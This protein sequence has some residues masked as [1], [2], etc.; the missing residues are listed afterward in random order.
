MCKRTMYKRARIP[1][2]LWE[3]R[4]CANSGAQARLGL[5]TLCY[6]FGLICFQEILVNITHNA[7]H[8]AHYALLFTV[9]SQ[10]VSSQTYPL[11]HFSPVFV[12]TMD[13]IV[14]NP[15]LILDDPELVFF[16]QYLQL[17]DNAIQHIFED[18]VEFFNE[19]FGL[20]FFHL[21]TKSKQPVLLRE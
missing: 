2:F 15:N 5:S 3:R 11:D 9:S 14:D 19:T 20:N 18:A 1:M 7:L 21:N 12:A 10:A 17:K 13:Q 8:F 6:L 16:K 4:A